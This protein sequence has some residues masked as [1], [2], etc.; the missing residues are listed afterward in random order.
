MTT[1]I[2][3]LAMFFGIHVLTST[4]LRAVLVG[5]VGENP[6][7]GVF[8]VLSF[9][10]LGLI[11]WG[12]VLARAMPEA[13]ALVFTS[14]AWSKPVTSALILVGLIIIGSG[15]GKGYIRKIVK[16]PMSVGIGVWAIAHLLS[17]GHLNEVM[18]F[19]SFLA[20][21]VYD[22]VMST[23]KGK[24]PTYDPELKADIKAIVIGVIIFAVL[25]FFHATLFGVS[26]I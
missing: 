10:G 7:K 1:L 15:H 13:T 17:N 24:V 19:G 18:L 3:G 21:A 14:P 11:I 20:Y 8:S 22:F 4:P 2:I 23:L 12:F 6:Y 5:A 25:L 9:A 16:Q 26:V